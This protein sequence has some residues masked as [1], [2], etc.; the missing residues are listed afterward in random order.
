MIE[1]YPHPRSGPCCRLR[2]RI[3]LSRPP[4]PRLFNQHVLACRSRFRRK[5]RQHVVRRRHDHQVDIRRRHRR[6][7]IGRRPRSRMG[8][9]QRLSAP[10]I[11]VATNDKPPPRQ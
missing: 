8:R 6:A 7:P 9:S 4:R 1:S 10:A 2:D 3:Q 5:R 11:R